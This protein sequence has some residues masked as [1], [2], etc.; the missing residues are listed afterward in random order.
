MYRFYIAV[1]AS[2]LLWSTYAC[3]GS[4]R[5]RLKG[6]PVTVAVPYEFE[7]DHYDAAPKPFLHISHLP[8]KDGTVG[9]LLALHKLQ[10]T[11]RPK[12]LSQYAESLTAHAYRVVTPPTKLY[13]D[14]RSAI[15]VVTIVGFAATLADGSDATGHMLDFDLLI[16]D[17]N[18]YYHCSMD[19]VSN[20]KKY[21]EIF[22][23]FC[24]SVRFDGNNKSTPNKSLQPTAQLLRSRSAAELWR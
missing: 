7:V 16:K 10:P 6:T 21:R 1:I 19:G 11:E 4:H 13:V 23:K 5:V 14:G 24:L 18:S 2:I 22:D 3:A 15:K 12:S 17:G 8:R 9:P 20:T